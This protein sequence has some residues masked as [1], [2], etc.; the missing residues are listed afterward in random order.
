M[1]TASLVA[2]T[3]VLALSSVE[4]FTVQTPAPARHN[5]RLAYAAVAPELSPQHK[6]QVQRRVRKLSEAPE[7]ASAP[8]VEKKEK[9]SRHGSKDAIE[10]LTMKEFQEEVLDEKEKLV[11]VRF[12]APWCRA[13]KAIAP[14][15]SK[16]TK[17]TTKAHTDN[18]KFVDCPLTAVTGEVH[19]TLGVNTIPFAHV[20]HP[21]AGL[22]EERR[23]ARK[24]YMGFER[25]AKSY[26]KGECELKDGNASIDPS[27][28]VVQLAK[29]AA[30][31]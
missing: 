14:Y 20:Y 31:A 4:S 23:L 5:T 30:M 2:A 10:V 8:L 16:F 24:H 17:D 9:I 18:V 22:V 13:C 21:I 12:F 7:V 11:V 25:T 15:Y 28:N 6:N 1:K 29:E 19:Q 27:P 3:A 26:L